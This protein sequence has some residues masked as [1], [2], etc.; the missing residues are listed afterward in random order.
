MTALAKIEATGFAVTL[1]PNGNLGIIPADKL[2][3]IQLDYLK[4]HKAEIIAELESANYSSL[5]PLEQWQ[6]SA[7]T[8]WIQSLGGSEQ[9]LIEDTEDV[10]K[11]CRNKP[12]ALGYYL[13]RAA[14]PPM[15]PSRR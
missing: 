3:P 13:K 12:E 5:P 2:T 9:A 10:L 4:Q 6:I 8:A 14:E 11:Q 1:K 7:I 15:T